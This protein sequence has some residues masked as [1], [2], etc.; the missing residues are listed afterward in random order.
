MG[1]LRLPLGDATVDLCCTLNALEHVPEPWSFLEELVRV[2]RP[3][4][5]VFIGVTN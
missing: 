2:T 1:G 5:I 3:G 4:G